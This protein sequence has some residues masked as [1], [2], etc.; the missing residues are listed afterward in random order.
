MR[1]FPRLAAGAVTLA[2]A[3]P[4]LLDAVVAAAERY[5]MEMT[6]AEPLF[7]LRGPP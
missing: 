2:A 3:R 4:A 7:D 6:V 1:R 5:Q